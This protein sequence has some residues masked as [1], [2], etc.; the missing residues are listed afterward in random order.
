MLDG[1][2]FLVP[3]RLRKN[4]E[5]IQIKVLMDTEAQAWLFGDQKL[6]ELLIKRW[7]LSRIIYNHPVIIKELENKLIQTIRN[8]IPVFLQLNERTFYDTPLLEM[9]L[10]DRSDFQMIVG[11][12]FL[13]RYNI[14]TLD[15]ANKKLQIPKH[16]PKN[17]LW[18]KDIEISWNILT[19]KKTDVQAQKNMVQ[20]NK[21]WKKSESDWSS[22]SDLSV[23]LLQNIPIILSHNS[24]I[25]T[26]SDH[27]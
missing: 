7:R 27:T 5:I 3:I 25:P 11:L 4:G 22:L 17:P 24:L 19:A 12:K 14:T 20:K 15:C 21:K 1:D 13:A 8:F 23:N 16:I 9:N 26:T 2:F 18:Q 10:S 6:C